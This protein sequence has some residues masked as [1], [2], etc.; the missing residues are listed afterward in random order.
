MKKPISYLNSIFFAL[1]LCH[2]SAFLTAAHSKYSSGSKIEKSKVPDHLRQFHR[3]HSSSRPSNLRHLYIEQRPERQ[4]ATP[5][6]SPPHLRL[7]PKRSIR[8]T[9][10][11]IVLKD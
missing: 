3:A 10:K 6:I 2:Y 7:P 1:L 4:P 8:T 9:L 5:E 11:A